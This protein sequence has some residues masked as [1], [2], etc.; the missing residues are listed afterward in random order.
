MWRSNNESTLDEKMSERNSDRRKLSGKK[1][2]STTIEEKIK[3]RGGAGGG[4]EKG[5][6]E[7]ITEAGRSRRE[8]PGERDR[9]IW[10]VYGKESLSL[11]GGWRPRRKRT[12]VDGEEKKKSRKIQVGNE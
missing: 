11:G 5:G 1:R 9:S 6:E 7:A 10:R 3:R 8:S 12:E 4:K 2:K